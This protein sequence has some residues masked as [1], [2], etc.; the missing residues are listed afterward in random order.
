MREPSSKKKKKKR[1]RRRR[2]RRKE[3]RKEKEERGIGGVESTIGKWDFMKL[4]G[5]Y[6][7]KDRQSHE[8]SLQNERK[9]FTSYTFDTELTSVQR[10]QKP[11]TRTQT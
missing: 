1:R 9:I 5:F 6:T 10:T 7:A 3:G 11:K 4:K 2:R 8:D